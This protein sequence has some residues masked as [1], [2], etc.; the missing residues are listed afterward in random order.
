MSNS[1]KAPNIRE[2]ILPFVRRQFAFVAQPMGGG[3]DPKSN[4]NA[5]ETGVWR[6]IGS[7]GRLRKTG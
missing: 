1:P 3:V 5:A 6:G 4:P 7:L 2:L